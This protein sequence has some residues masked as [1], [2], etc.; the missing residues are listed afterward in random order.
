MAVCLH[1]EVKTDAGGKR[2]KWAVVTVSDSGPGIPDVVMAKL[3][4]PFFTT[5]GANGTGL[6]LWVS[7]GIATKHGGTLELTSDMTNT[8]NGTVAQVMLPAL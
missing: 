6:G 3:F 4:Q 8:V 5:K 7:R 1:A 2:K